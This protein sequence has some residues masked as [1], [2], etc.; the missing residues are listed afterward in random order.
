MKNMFLVGGEMV[1]CFRLGV[2]ISKSTNINVN[3]QRFSFRHQNDRR[4]N[5]TE[6]V[7]LPN[8]N[9]AL[10]EVATV[11]EYVET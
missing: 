6:S 3:R 9:P 1:F 8:V 11:A 10:V 2:K 5:Q 7:K 4:F